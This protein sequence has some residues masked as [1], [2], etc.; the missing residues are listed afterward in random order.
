M[1]APGGRSGL[2]AERTRLAWQRTALGLFANGTLHLLRHQVPSV[3]NL[4]VAVL[5]V[6]L[7]LAVIVFGRRRSRELLASPLP[8]PLAPRR[9]V[10]VLGGAVLL[11]GVLTAAAIT[12][13]GSS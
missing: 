6:L 12:A 5:S 2:Q 13:G 9:P 10:L 4:V 7:A 3:L 8:E 11:L 1:T